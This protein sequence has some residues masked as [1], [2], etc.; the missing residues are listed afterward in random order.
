MFGFTRGEETIRQA[1]VTKVDG[2]ACWTKAGE[3]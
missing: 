1:L 3:S 2:S